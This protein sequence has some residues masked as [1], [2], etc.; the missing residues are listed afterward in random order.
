MSVLYESVAVSALRETGPQL[1]SVAVP[2]VTD[3]TL[4]APTQKPAP[5]STRAPPLKD[6]LKT[7]GIA[8]TDE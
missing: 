4:P 3:M 1:L 5:G 2:T 7:V 6:Q 8:A